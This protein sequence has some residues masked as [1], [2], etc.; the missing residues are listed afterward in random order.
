MQRKRGYSWLRQK[1]KEREKK[2][3]REKKERGVNLEQMWINLEKTLK[4]VRKVAI[5]K[6]RARQTERKR[7]ISVDETIE[8]VNWESE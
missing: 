2:S 1:K 3:E 6:L 8:D 5:Y 4:K 7:K